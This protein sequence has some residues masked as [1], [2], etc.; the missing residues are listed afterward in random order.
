MRIPSIPIATALLT[1]SA[2]TLGSRPATF[3]P[4]R[5][6]QGI[7]ARITMSA[8]RYT[9]ATIVG[10]LLS[11]TDSG[12]VVLSA[13]RRLLYVHW[14]A[15]RYATFRQIGVRLNAGK[16][17]DARA[18]EQL[19]LVSRFPQ[20]MSPELTARLLESLG[21]ERVEVLH[22]ETSARADSAAAADGGSRSDSL[23][24]AAARA[25]SA[26]YRDLDSAVAD[27]FRLVGG[28]FPGMGEHWV[29]AGRLMAGVIDASRPAIL[30]YAT[31]EGRPALVGVAYAVPLGAGD[32]LPPAP[33]DAWHAHSGSVDE[34]SFLPRHAGH[35]A[36]GPGARIAV[37]HAWV[38][39]DNPDGPFA[40][41]NRALPFARAGLA[42]EPAPAPAL[43]ALAL[44][45]GAVP[46]YA[47][48]AA[49]VSDPGE[50]G[51]EDLTRLLD[52]AAARVR[53]A[54]AGHPAGL[55]RTELASLW[56]DLWEEIAA[57]EPRAAYAG[58]LGFA[59]EQP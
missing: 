22:G 9:A 44:A 11:V 53:T 46:F 54:I 59:A 47:E 37:L 21:R 50:A 45:Y 41:D 40:T 6:P 8:P 52:G 51:R 18:Q 27:G 43:R 13:D 26:R 25:G 55:P 58:G 4:A 23:F 10:E 15:L 48:A 35:S 7:E 28:D 34:A 57:L 14:P 12:L 5:S 38:W 19:R 2:C 20:G 29:H 31:I 16:A 24:L 36:G 49:R 30:S 1:L 17:P 56:E 42:P 32:P 3:G 33:R 39:L